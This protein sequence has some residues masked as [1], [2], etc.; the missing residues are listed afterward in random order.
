MRAKK[1]NSNE[2]YVLSYG[3]PQSIIV[4][5][6]LPLARVCPSGLN[7][8]LQTALECPVSV[9]SN[10]PVCAFQSLIE[11]SVLPLARVCLSGLNAT[12]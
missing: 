6:S 3:M 9:L 1:K 12:L 5:S 7:A 8:T 4:L 10:F 11:V 2:N